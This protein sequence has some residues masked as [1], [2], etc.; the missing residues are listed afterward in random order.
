MQ[1]IAI[2]R[3]GRTGAG[4][5]ADNASSKLEECSS[6]D[7]DYYTSVSI[8]AANPQRRAPQQV[9]AT[10]RRAKFLEVAA[11]MIAQSG[12]EAVTM[13]AIAAG[14]KASIGTLYD[15]FP[16]K[17][18][19]A[20]ALMAQYTKELDEYWKALLQDAGKLT[21][22]AMTDLFIDGTLMLVR[23]RPA[24]LPLMGASIAYTRSQSMR[25]PLR[26]TIV[27][28]LRAKNP[29]LPAESAFINA[30]VIVQLLKGL[31]AVYRETAPKERDKVAADFRK[32]MNIYLRDSLR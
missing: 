3:L 16:D 7:C 25:R 21:R 8:A 12:Y 22:T 20:W 6:S 11:N 2:T 5:F 26:Q 18:S 19:L 30:E 17:Q 32:L 15:Y 9:R 10:L 13:T 28:A 29:K 4:L 27:D 23:A 31:L 24:Y 1:Q 14:A